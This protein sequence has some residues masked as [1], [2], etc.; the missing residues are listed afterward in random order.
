[1]QTL[2]LHHIPLCCIN[3]LQIQHENNTIPFHYTRHHTHSNTQEPHVPSPLTIIYP[4]PHPTH[5]AS[6]EDYISEAGQCC[7]THKPLL[8]P[9]GIGQGVNARRPATLS[10]ASC[11]SEDWRCVS[12]AR[13]KS[14]EVVLTFRAF[15]ISCLGFQKVMFALWIR[16]VYLYLHICI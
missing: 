7:Q 16:C 4:P 12:L 3:T 5:K 10:L 9:L 13:H 8:I 11:K 6:Q 1:M 15:V 14:G 2:T